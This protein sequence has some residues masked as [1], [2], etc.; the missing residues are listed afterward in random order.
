MFN[1]SRRILFGLG[2]V[3]P[4]LGGNVLDPLANAFGLHG[5]RRVQLTKEFLV[6]VKRAIRLGRLRLFGPTPLALDRT[7]LPET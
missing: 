1:D 2:F 7:G 6:T 5:G 3:L 4:P